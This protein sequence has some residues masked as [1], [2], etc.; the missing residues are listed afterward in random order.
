VAI[1]IAHNK[2]QIHS[3]CDGFSFSEE[4]HD[5]QR[6]EQRH[7]QRHVFGSPARISHGQC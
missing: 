3:Y 4:C 2:P 7:E 1:A 6:H 5:C